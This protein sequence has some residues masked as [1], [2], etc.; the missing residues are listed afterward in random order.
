[1]KKPSLQLRFVYKITATEATAHVIIQYPFYKMCE[2]DLPKFCAKKVKTIDTP[3][4][5]LFFLN[6]R[7]RDPYFSFWLGSQEANNPIYT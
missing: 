5:Q 7:S 2:K 6:I 3:L 1:M 4:K